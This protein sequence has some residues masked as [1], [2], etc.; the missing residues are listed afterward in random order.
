MSRARFVCAMAGGIVSARLKLRGFSKGEI[1]HY[2]VQARETMLEVV[3]PT[4]FLSRAPA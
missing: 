1:S 3:M 4:F 2:D